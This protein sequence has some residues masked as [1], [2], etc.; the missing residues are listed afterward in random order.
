MP[1]IQTQV[2]DDLCAAD[3]P[4]GAP[5]APSGPTKPPVM[6]GTLTVWE[7]RLERG[8]GADHDVR[9]SRWRNMHLTAAVSAYGTPR[10]SWRYRRPRASLA[11][12]PLRAVQIIDGKPTSAPI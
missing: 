3:T 6:N 4:A 1:T 5:S 7:S 2:P 10:C 12:W 9:P 11:P 8:A